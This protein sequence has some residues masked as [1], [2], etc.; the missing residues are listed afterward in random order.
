MIFVVPSVSASASQ[1]QRRRVGPGRGAH[2]PGQPRGEDPREEGQPAPQLLGLGGRVTA[3]QCARKARRHGTP[4][5]ATENQVV[6]GWLQ[7]TTHAAQQRCSRNTVWYDDSD[8]ILEWNA[9]VALGR[10]RNSGQGSPHP[11]NE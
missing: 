6:S 10:R 9:F 4:A 8:S 3:T 5:A 1:V 11:W 2:R 7:L